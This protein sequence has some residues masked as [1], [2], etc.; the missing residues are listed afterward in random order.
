MKS[1][2]ALVIPLVI[3]F[4]GLVVLAKPWAINEPRYSGNVKV[5]FHASHAV[6]ARGLE[7]TDAE[8]RRID[9]HVLRRHETVDSVSVHLDAPRDAEKEFTAPKAQS[10][11]YKMTIQT[12]R[13]TSIDTKWTR[14]NRR[15]LVNDILRGLDNDIARYREMLKDT[16]KNAD[17]KR[18]VM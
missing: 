16:Y 5:S 12:R 6:V 14:T 3:V 8:R 18:V 2:S 11:A 4:A 17:L 7:L 13:K 9:H 10:M 15:E 1:F